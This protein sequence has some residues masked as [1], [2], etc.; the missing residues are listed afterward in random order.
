MTDSSFGSKTTL[1]FDWGNTLMKVFPQYEGRMADWPEVAAE[2]GIRQALEELHGRYPMAVATNATESGAPQVWQALKRAG[3]DE[4]FRAVFTSQELGGARKPAVG[5][6][7]QLE[8][9]LVRSPHQLVMIGDDYR[10]DMLGAKEAGW[11]AIWYNPRH[12][13]A[14]GLL[15]LHDGEVQDL[16][17]LP[18][19]LA[20]RNLPDYPTCLAWLAGRG[21]PYNILAH[22]HLVAAAAYQISVWLAAKGETI[23]PVLVHRGGLLHD[24]AKIDT[25]TQVKAHEQYGD[26]ARMARDQLLELGQPELAEIAD[27]HMPYTDPNHPRRP[28]NWE[29]RLVHY[30]DKLAEGARL[31]PIEDRLRALQGRYPMAAAD[32]EKSWPILNE[33][34]MEI[35]ARLEITPS[36]LIERL[37]QAL[38]ETF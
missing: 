5:F 3:L 6:F 14:A 11:R 24:L 18:A 1:V 29:Q 10:G 35:C 28:L 25:V 31:V 2:D 38:G 20:Q 8:S 12:Q 37:R 21:T 19:A 26:H 9:V 7:H 4:Y 15:P 33:L 30:A 13:A 16:R 34:Q 32:L 36:E 17:T 27:R 22:V 23:N